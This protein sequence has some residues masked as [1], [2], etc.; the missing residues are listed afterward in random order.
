MLDTLVI[1]AGQAGLATAH[2]LNRAGV[3]P[4]ILEAGPE[5]V[6]AWPRYYDSLTLFSPA[7]HSQLP[8]LPFDGDPHRYPTRDDV[9]D[10]LRRYATRLDADIRTN[11]RV[12]TVT[13]H[14]GAFEAATATG[15]L[16]TAR[17]VI[18]ATGGFGR[19][20]RP[21]LPGLDAFGGA[22][23]H[24]ADYRHP[25]QFTGQRIL[26]VGAGNS[27]VQIAVDL[28]QHADVT[29]TS[30]RPVRWVNQRPAGR[31]IHDW[32]AWTRLQ[33]H[34]ISRLLRHQGVSVLDDGTYRR[35]ITSGRPTWRP[36]FDYLD[37]DK[38]TWADGSIERVD[39]ILLATGFRAQTEHLATLTGPDG[40]RAAAVDG[41]PAHQHG[42]STTVPG[43]GFVGLEWQR[44]F[45]SA[46]LRGVGPD[47]A[48]V[49]AKIRNRP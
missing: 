44:G 34:P 20:H 9:V 3:T 1:G 32:L 21:P 17:H 26:V 16:I 43:L 22:V 27:A 19:P 12:T 8:S 7:R 46:T 28:A 23:L 49:L 35:A 29:L 47:A 6:G 41:T 14:N 4:L 31:D 48:R 18:S 2:H 10:Y 24:S 36:L 38:V 37:G 5:P 39:V 15:D 45:A 11:T 42:V 25:G 30:R 33:H 40:G 13:L